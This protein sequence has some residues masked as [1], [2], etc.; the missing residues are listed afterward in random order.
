M[1]HH[2]LPVGIQDATYRWGGRGPTNILGMINLSCWVLKKTFTL[3]E[4]HSDMAERL[5]GDLEI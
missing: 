3:I 4:A 2:Q 1:I 5:V